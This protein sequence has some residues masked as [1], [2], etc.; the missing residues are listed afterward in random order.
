[1]MPQD[2]SMA[3][4]FVPGQAILS[5]GDEALLQ[6]RTDTLG[7]AYRLF[8]EEPFHPVRGEGGVAL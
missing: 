8:Y 1:M 2:Q 3:N 6:R 4:A 5:A 7:P